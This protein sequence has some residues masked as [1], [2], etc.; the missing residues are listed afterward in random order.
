M[1]ERIKKLGLNTFLV[2]IGKAGSSI[3]GLLML[4]FYTHWLSTDEYGTTDL[5][6]TY[7]SILMG[8]M[9]CCVADAIF[10]FPK[11]A[12]EKG[13]T[14]YYT[15]GYIFMALMTGLFFVIMALLEMIGKHLSWTGVLIDKVWYVFA[16]GVCQ[17]LQQY[18]QSF[19]RSIDRMRVFSVSGVVYTGAIAF[20]SF[21]LLP[22]FG[23][24]GYLFAMLSAMLVATIYTVI[25]SRSYLYFSIGEFDKLSLIQLLKY[26]IPL[27]PNS[28]M[29]WIV[30]GI[31][32]P[33]MEANLGLDALG[34]YAVANKFPLLLST[35]VTVFG[36]AWGITMLEEFGKPDFNHFFNK[37]LRVL[38]YVMIVGACLIASCS[39]LIIFIFADAAYFDAWKYIPILTLGIVLQNYSGIIG[40]I[41]MAEKTSKYYFYSSIW[42]AVASLVATITCIKLFGLQGAAIA[43]AFSFLV[44]SVARLVYAWKHINEMHVGWFVVMT[45]LYILFCVVVLMDAPLY[46]NIPLY[47]IIL[48]VISVLSKQELIPVWMTIKQRLGGK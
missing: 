25:A 16:F 5:I 27:I 12:D 33:I 11:D 46:V 39:K 36:T 13:R 6:T 4:P 48:L 32:R 28:L 9:S 31:N 30:N 29:W 45:L 19:T 41:F 23:L 15:S 7:A 42:G 8:I 3:I 2:F 22:R 17:F 40:G 20:F 10:V 47:A 34:I 18:S 35:L 26:G 24:D 1:Q 14:R 43:I 37:T 21:F 38:F 44:M